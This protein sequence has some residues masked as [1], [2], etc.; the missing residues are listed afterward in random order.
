MHRECFHRYVHTKVIKRME[1]ARVRGP[2]P[3]SARKL[4]LPLSLG[5]S[6]LALLQILDVYFDG[7][8]KRTGRADVEL[9][10][11]F[12]DLN[13]GRDNDSKQPLE[14]VR[15]LFPFHTYYVRE[16]LPLS[17]TS[18]ASLTRPGVGEAVLGNAQSATSD[19]TIHDIL[20][21]LPSATS[22]ADMLE[23]MLLLNIVRA[24]Q[25]IHC[26][27]I[28]WGDTTTRLSEKILAET[29]KGRGFALPWLVNDGESPY[30]PRF[31]FPLR[32]LLRKEVSAYVRLTQ[33]ALGNLVERS[34]VAQNRVSSRNVTIDG[35][36]QD[37]F[38]SVEDNY[39]SIVTNVTR[40]VG[41]L[42]PPSASSRTSSCTTCG[43][44]YDH[45]Q[46]GLLDWAGN[47][48]TRYSND[49]AEL[50]PGT[51]YGCTRTLLQRQQRAE[52]ALI[53]T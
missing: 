33:P 32:D 42:E 21:S 52:K 28:L 48:E 10:V 12:V 1:A 44:P 16:L 47:Q 24:A 29:A 2:K 15:A 13:Y 14:R 41:K 49:G 3:T 40:T 35:I 30:G 45:G 5:V 46:P 7:Q 9:H 53:N 34:P 22:Q 43:L 50:T 18:S 38:E 39:P 20:S 19:T 36:M 23:K 8:R 25:E 17:E 37:Y 6:S 31:C 4:L 26:E 51:C 11:L 27:S